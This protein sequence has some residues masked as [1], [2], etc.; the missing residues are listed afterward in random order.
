MHRFVVY[1]PKALRPH[2]DLR[3]AHLLGNDG[4]PIRGEIKLVG[5][6]IH[7]RARTSDPC[8]LSLL[9]PVPGFG[10]VQ[11]ETT[12][13][14]ERREPYILNVELARHRLMRISIKREEWGLFDYRGMEDL[15]AQ[16]EQARERFVTALEHSDSPA[17]AAQLADESL[18]VSSDVADR[19]CQF[20]ASIFLGRRQ[21]GNGF[22]GDLFGAAVSPS[23]SPDRLSPAVSKLLN[24]VR[25]PLV[26]RE[27]QPKENAERFD[28]VDAWVKACR[29]AR[30]S[31]KGGPLL[32]FGVRAVPDW[33]YV[34]ENDFET[35]LDYARQ[36]IQRCVRRYADRVSAWIVAS[37]LHADCVFSFNFEQIMEITRTAAVTARELA[38]RA[39]VVLDIT[40]PWGEYFARNPRSIPPL[41]YADMVIQSGIPVD[42]FGVQFL[43]GIDSEG[44]HLRDM[45]QISALIDRLAGFGKPLHITAVA[46]PSNPPDSDP[47]SAG[48]QWRQA[49]SEEAQAAW[50]VAFCEVALSKPYVESVCL[51]SLVDDQTETIPSS[52]IFRA[53]GSPK[54]AFESLRGFAQG[55]AGESRP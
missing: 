39:Q 50:L 40:Q 24:F 20:H 32:Q 7:C 31:I 45:L 28:S 17:K 10:T 23:L 41:L 55:L 21:Q 3:G 18:Q 54:P 48:G 36:H 19:M 51:H 4:I 38:P 1:P 15:S 52:G 9:W 13:L 37:G 14:P 6:E 34:W 47:F 25:I 26:W 12:R 43:F 30:L 29:A 53:D 33:M 5:N 2:I 44:Y 11:L 8:A 27:I 22:R 49:W 16:I 42:A 46:V 35:I